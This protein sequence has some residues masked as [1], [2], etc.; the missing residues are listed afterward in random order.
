MPL[1]KKKTIG[2]DHAKRTRYQKLEIQLYGDLNI[3]FMPKKIKRFEN[4]MSMIRKASISYQSDQRIP[5]K[6][7]I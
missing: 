2:S 7:V 3:E 1:K 6:S 5:S 4:I